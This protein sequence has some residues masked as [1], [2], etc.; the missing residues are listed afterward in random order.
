GISFS[1]WMMG[2]KL[3]DT[4]IDNLLE[5]GQL[6]TFMDA[7]KILG[8]MVIGALTSQYVFLQTKLSLNSG[9]ETISFQEDVLDEI[10]PNL[11]PLLL[12][13]AVFKLLNIKITPVKI[14]GILAIIGAIGA[15]L[16]IFEPVEEMM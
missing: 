9:E 16:G 6:N 12:T 7:A 2:N 5:S 11:L 3:G 1:M 4:A 10:M 15:V 14:I 8:C 13:L